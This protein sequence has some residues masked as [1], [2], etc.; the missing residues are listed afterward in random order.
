MMMVDV[1]QY[2]IHTQ[3]E[4]L[5]RELDKE[6]P[7]P[8]RL[9]TRLQLACDSLE[10]QKQSLR[11]L[12]RKFKDI[13]AQVI[14]CLNR[15]VPVGAEHE[16][17]IAVDSAWTCKDQLNL[18]R[19]AME[20]IGPECVFHLVKANGLKMSEVRRAWPEGY[21]KYYEFSGTG[22]CKVSRVKRRGGDA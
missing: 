12:E 8:E 15:P 3:L 16:L 18:M 5:D 10:F 1:D 22:E 21:A 19:E 9:E 7:D 4:I 14:S 20:T 17:R 11:E 2:A 6:K 13:A